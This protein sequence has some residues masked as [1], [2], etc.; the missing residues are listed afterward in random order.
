MAKVTI[1]LEDGDDGCVVNVEFEPEL[2]TAGPHTQAQVMA[3][4][5]MNVIHSASDSMSVT[6]ER[7]DDCEDD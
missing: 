1:T 7:H 6:G 2:I 4:A 5:I 3:V